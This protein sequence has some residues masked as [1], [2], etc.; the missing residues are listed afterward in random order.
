MI[1]A[2]LVSFGV[3]LILMLLIA[4]IGVI[5]IMFRFFNWFFVKWVLENKS[6][7]TIITDEVKKRSE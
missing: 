2:I 5:V 1:D 3:I 4:G 6:I 7:D